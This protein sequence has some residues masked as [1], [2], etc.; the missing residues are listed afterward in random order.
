MAPNLTLLD[1]GD[2]ARSVMNMR[3]ECDKM[4]ALLLPDEEAVADAQRCKHPPDK[5]EEEGDMGD[6]ITYRCTACNT[7][8]DT[9]FHSE[10]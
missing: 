4:L 7:T 10:V 3:D 9:P 6:D 5:L 8:Q 1:R 2:M